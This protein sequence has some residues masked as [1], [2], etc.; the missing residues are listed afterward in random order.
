M[1]DFYIFEGAKGTGKSTAIDRLNNHLYYPTIHETSKTENTFDWQKRLY[2]MFNNLIMDRSFIGELVYPYIYNRK[3]K[4]N[5]IDSVVLLKLM[6]P[7]IYL[8][9][10]GSAHANCIIDRVYTRDNTIT[11]KQANEIE[12]S[13]NK[14]MYVGQL[15]YEAYKDLDIEFID[16]SKQYLSRKVEEDYVISKSK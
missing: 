15:L 4:I 13:N 7:K 2:N 1:K 8:A 14:F 3:P 12:E 6:K 5:F 16:V 9:Y 11:G 10:D